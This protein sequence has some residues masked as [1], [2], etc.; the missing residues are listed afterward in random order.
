MGPFTRLRKTGHSWSKIKEAL[1]VMKNGACLLRF[2]R[3]FTLLLLRRAHL[4]SDWTRKEPKTKK[5]SSRLFLSS[6][7]KHLGDIIIRKLGVTYHHLIMGFGYVIKT[8]EWSIKWL[9]SFL[10][11]T[12]TVQLI[13]FSIDRKVSWN[14]AFSAKLIHEVYCH[15][16]CVD[17]LSRWFFNC[18]RLSR[19]RGRSGRRLVNID[20]TLFRREVR[21]VRVLAR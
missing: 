19:F 16:G 6:E 11:L 1:A 2:R 5:N 20:R 7:L 10:N 21:D 17:G 12:A 13:T 14:S 4:A 18:G 8:L 3:K 9:K 15:Y